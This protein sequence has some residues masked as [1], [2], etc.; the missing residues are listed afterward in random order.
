MDRS[1]QP[2]LLDRADE[3]KR[4]AELLYDSRQS[5]PFTLAVY[6]DWGMGKSSLLNQTAELLEQEPNVEVVRFNAWT[7]GQGD[8]LEI[9]IKSVL[10]RLDDRT[11]RRLARAVV[12]DTTVSAWCH[13]LLRG[14]AGIVRAHHLVDGIW[15]QLEMDAR[16]RNNAQD[17]LRRT[18]AEFTAGDKAPPG[19]RSI[20][21]FV[22]DLDRC[23]PET[24]RVVCSAIKQY[25]NVPG[26]VFVLAC[27]RAIVETAVTGTAG[28]GRLFLEKIIQAY[29]PI[30][31]PTDAQITD[32]IQ[33]YAHNAGAAELFKTDVVDAVARHADRNPRRIKQLM[34]RLV[35]EYRLDPEWM[36]LGADSLIRAALLQDLYPDFYRLLTLDPEF[37]P[38][39]DFDGY[40]ALTEL[41]DGTQDE[42]ASP[43][44]E[45]WTRARQFLERRNI[46]VP[47]NVTAE[48]LEK[49]AHHLPEGFATLVEDRTFVGLALA[50]IN[51]DT[52]TKRLRSKLRRRRI[53]VTEA[54]LATFPDGPN[55][56]GLDVLW[57]S[58]NSETGT[59]VYAYLKRGGAHVTSVQTVEE[60]LMHLSA[61]QYD[62]L[63]C[64]LYRPDSERDGFDD[65]EQIRQSGYDGRVIVFT[66]SVS[67]ARRVRALEVD[68]L[69]SANDSEV[70]SWIPPTAEAV[71]SPPPAPEDA[72]IHS[73]PRPRIQDI[74]G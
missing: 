32:L 71:Q 49:V 63:L 44:D 60:A 7:A 1:G 46:P 50:L 31:A 59:G 6:A 69:I 48:F 53:E 28:D 51:S 23:P 22:D 43:D 38:L 17:L 5:A 19:G 13:V 25:L 57:F 29:F 41:A 56:A 55:V 11:L 73:G 34:N 37:D 70:I 24:I 66:G 68:A 62:V 64:N 40:L 74:L 65:I 61:K 15:D 72:H 18:L 33:G 2:D 3:A 16:T 14:L 26:L 42:A 10:D 39:E 12:G 35:V 20:V 45:L 8:S 54:N 47:N 4:L 30:A 21:V 9:L 67:H 36:A 58:T 27:D 52:A